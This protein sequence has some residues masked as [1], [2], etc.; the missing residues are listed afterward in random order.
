MIFAGVTEIEARAA[1]I[2]TGFAGVCAS[3][4]GVILTIR[5]VRSREQK[6]AAQQLKT[7]E[8]YLSEE[9]TNRIDAEQALHKA[10]VVLVQ[11]GIAPPI[12]KHT[13]QPVKKVDDESDDD[14]D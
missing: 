9:R 4:G 8:E 10:D 14:T 12:H 11:H 7:V 13:T 1:A 2:I 5:R 3:V 6:A